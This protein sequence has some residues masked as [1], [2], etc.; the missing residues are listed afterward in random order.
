VVNP[1]G[2][3]RSLRWLR[4]EGGWLRVEWRRHRPAWRRGT[5]VGAGMMASEP[6]GKGESLNWAVNARDQQQPPEVDSEM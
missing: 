2:C 1:A 6:R 3:G 5:P 4:V